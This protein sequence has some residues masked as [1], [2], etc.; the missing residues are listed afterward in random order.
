MSATQKGPFP[1]GR[2]R[3][4]LGPK[5]RPLGVRQGLFVTALQRYFA[6]LAAMSANSFRLQRAK[7][8]L[9]AN[10]GSAKGKRDR[11]SFSY[12]V[13]HSGR[14]FAPLSRHRLLTQPSHNPAPAT[15]SP[16]TACGS[17]PSPHGLLVPLRLALDPLLLSRATRAR[18]PLSGMAKVRRDDRGTDARPSRLISGAFRARSAS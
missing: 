3:R 6:P 13:V 9:A 8:S 5:R 14:P 7:S 2:K 16:T 11:C 15:P 18:A 10:L 4:P 12:L 17:L 1:L